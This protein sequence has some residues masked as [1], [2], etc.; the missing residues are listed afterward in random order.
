MSDKPTTA[1]R[2]QAT[3][4]WPDARLKALESVILDV[5]RE[6]WPQSLRHV[7]YRCVDPRLPVYV[8][9]DDS[10][11]QRVGRAVKLMRR[12]GALPYT[13]IADYS[14]SAYR[15]DT[16]DGAADFIRRTHGLYRQSLWET[17]SP[18]RVEVWCESQSIASVIAPVCA[19][20]AVALYPSRGD[21]SDSFVYAG[22]VQI[23]DYIRRGRGVAVLYVGDYDPSGVGIEDVLESKLKEHVEREGADPGRFAVYRLAVTPQQIAD[24]NLPTRP[25]KPTDRRRPDVAVS[26]E[27]EAIPAGVMRDLVRDAIES[28]LNPGAL[29]RVRVAE[30]SEKTVLKRLAEMLGEE[31]SID[32]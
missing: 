21:S 28:Y 24:W 8:S 18:Y 30:E 13:W 19:E 4:R 32:G 2:R 10:G 9:K 29:E 7:F 6:D 15:V 17:E 1:R 14:R 23:A 3:D 22:A 16:Y 31:P 27:A 5:L 25:R 26:V 11:Y 12:R 20:S